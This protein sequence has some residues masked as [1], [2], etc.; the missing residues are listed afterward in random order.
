MQPPV[1]TYWEGKEMPFVNQVCVSSIRRVFGDRHR[2]LGPKD[3]KDLNIEVPAPV[4]GAPSKFARFDYLR[5]ALLQRLGGWWFDCD[6]LLFR[7]PGPE[8]EGSDCKI[9]QEMA[10]VSCSREGF[11]KVRGKWVP[12]LDVGVLFTRRAESA[13]LTLV[14]ETCRSTRRFGKSRAAVGDV[15]Q[16]SAHAV[17]A[18]GTERVDIGSFLAFYGSAEYW[19]DWVGLCVFR[20]D[21][22]RQYGV[23]LYTNSIARGEAMYTK[24]PYKLSKTIRGLSSHAE[25]VK[26]FPNS[27]FA[28]Y[29]KLYC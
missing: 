6:I 29:I 12:M 20:P 28:Q 10:T 19:W 27:V 11:D 23:S 17:N 18:R 8:V 5:A 25:A 7:D 2:H 22:P 13:W 24:D 16:N 9:W 3:L 21:D 4:A 26:L 15:I 14:L 1:F